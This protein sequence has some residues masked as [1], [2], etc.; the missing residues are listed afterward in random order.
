MKRKVSAASSSWIVNRHW[1]GSG[2]L[3]DEILDR[4][5]FYTMPSVKVLAAHYRQ[6]YNEVSYSCASQRVVSTQ[7]PT[8]SQVD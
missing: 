1:R 7:L 4:E 5:I 3:R 8:M 6:M 2:K